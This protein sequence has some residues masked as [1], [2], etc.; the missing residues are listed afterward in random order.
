M[1]ET[2]RIWGQHIALRR[3]LL[4]LTQAELG[5]AMEPPVRQSTVARWESGAME[6][7]RQYKAQLAAVLKA[8]VRMLFP[9]TA[10]AA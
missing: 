3:K 7:R 10:G 2:L 4:G 5:E 9:M 8:D 1:D 6:P